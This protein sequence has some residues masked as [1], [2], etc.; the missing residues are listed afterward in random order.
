MPNI[1]PSGLRSQQYPYSALVFASG[2]VA[3]GLHLGYRSIPE[4]LEHSGRTS[5]AS[6]KMERKDIPSV[7]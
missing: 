2:P 7:S 1:P 5:A 3:S 4:K 6:F